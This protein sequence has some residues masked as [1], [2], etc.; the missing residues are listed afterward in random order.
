MAE[1]KE[2]FNILDDGSGN[3]DAPDGRKQGEA[4]ATAEGSVG[5]AAENAANNVELLQIQTENSTA[6]GKGQAVLPV[7]DEFGNIQY[8]PMNNGA[9]VVTD[10]A[11]GTLLR[12]AANGVVATAG[13][14]QSAVTL[15]LALTKIYDDLEIMVSSFKDC[16]WQITYIDDADGGGETATLIDTIRTGAGSYTIKL[17][18]EDYRLDTSGGTNNQRIAIDVTQR[19]GTG[20]D[21]SASIGILE[22]V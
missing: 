6:P 18:Y 14:P 11:S 12:S 16:S 4:Y 21:Y 5:F 1:Q 8:I 15:N 3:G 17:K 13:A 2:I 9:I 20:S 19:S 10:E 7:K 22:R